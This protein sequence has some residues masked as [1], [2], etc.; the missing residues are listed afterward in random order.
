MAETKS[1]FSAGAEIAL[2]LAAIG[3]GLVQVL[4]PL[5]LLNVAPLASLASTTPTGVGPVLIGQNYVFGAA[6]ILF[7]VGLYYMAI[8]KRKRG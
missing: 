1:L 5:A 7:G 6:F 3:L 2:A 4:A 8:R